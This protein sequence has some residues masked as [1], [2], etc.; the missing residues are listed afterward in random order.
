MAR[1]PA[2]EIY[3]NDPRRHGMLFWDMDC[4]LPLEPKSL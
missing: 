2:M 3:H 4:V 1:T